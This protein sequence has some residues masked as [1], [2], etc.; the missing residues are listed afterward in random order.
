M[1]EN[2]C[3]FDLNVIVVNPSLSLSCSQQD[4][5]LILA[6]SIT[7][8][9]NPA[10]IEWIG[11]LNVYINSSFFT[12]LTYQ[13]DVCN[14]EFYSYDGFYFDLSQYPIFN[15]FD[16]YPIELALNISSEITSTNITVN[17]TV[18]CQEPLCFR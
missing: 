15:Y 3:P 2:D 1:S 6:A 13:C 11:N 5:V 16:I 9:C 8:R 18:E 10:T 7:N 17:V 14:E 12:T 4:C